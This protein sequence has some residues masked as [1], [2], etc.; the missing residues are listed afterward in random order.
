[1]M[2]EV[3]NNE[4]YLWGGSMISF[5]K[6]H[7]KYESGREGESFLT[8][9]AARKVAITIYLGE[10]LNENQDLLDKLGKHTTGKGCL[11]IKKLKD[12]N[13]QAL[14][15]LIVASV[16]KTREMYPEAK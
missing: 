6:Y 14:K 8:G 16:K 12:V 15:A 3:T 10:G 13:L 11:Y 7:Y 9:F 4:P 1:M 5:G 2:K